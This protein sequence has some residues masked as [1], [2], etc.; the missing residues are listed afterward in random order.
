M[1]TTTRLTV[2]LVHG[3]FAECSGYA[4]VTGE[5]QT[6]GYPSQRS[7]ADRLAGRGG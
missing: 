1:T 7:R 2:I 5:L 4:G 6:S 3:A